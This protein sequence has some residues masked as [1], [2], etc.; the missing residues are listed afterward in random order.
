MHIFAP[1]IP[2]P[3][4]IL[5]VITLTAICMVATTNLNIAFSG[6]A[7]RY[8]RQNIELRNEAFKGYSFRHINEDNFEYFEDDYI[9]YPMR[10][11]LYGKTEETRSIADVYRKIVRKLAEVK[12][13]ECDILYDGFNDD[14]DSVKLVYMI[15]GIEVN[16]VWIDISP[17]QH[18][19]DIIRKLIVENNPEQITLDFRYVDDF[20]SKRICI[21]KYRKDEHIATPDE[22][23]QAFN[24]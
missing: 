2:V 18:D 19:E 3:I 17:K 14:L 15:K 13:S 5:T 12:N 20:F 16:H 6:K 22:L 9:Y 11:D 7:N 8:K 21:S 23:R 24:G 10:T 1:K 4:I